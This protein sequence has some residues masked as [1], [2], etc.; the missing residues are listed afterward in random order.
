MQAHLP[1]GPCRHVQQRFLYTRRLLGTTFIDVCNINGARE[2]PR[3]RIAFK[4]E[5]T[6]QARLSWPFGL[7]DI[8]YICISRIKIIILIRYN[9]A[10]W[11]QLRRGNECGGRSPSSRL[12]SRSCSRSYYTWIDTTTLQFRT[13]LSNYH[14]DKW[15]DARF[16][17]HIN[18]DIINSICDIMS[19]TLRPFTPLSL[20]I[21][22]CMHVRVKKKKNGFFVLIVWIKST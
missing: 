4:N 3:P 21:Y 22:A 9:L 15:R 10:Q 5:D 2:Y 13:Q 12:A 7:Y 18:Y 8:A 11:S 14:L 1:P 20:S 6:I 17:R 19:C 16:K